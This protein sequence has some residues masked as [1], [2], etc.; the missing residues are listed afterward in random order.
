MPPC[1]GGDGGSTPPTRSNKNTSSDGGVFVYVFFINKIPV[2]ERR[3]PHGFE[4][5]Q[6]PPELLSPPP[7]QLPPESLPPPP[8]QLPPE[9][10]EDEED[11]YEEEEPE[12]L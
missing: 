8:P 12:L 2:Q 6:L 10:L 1:Q 4:V 5:H 7:P 11:E 3:F 9:L